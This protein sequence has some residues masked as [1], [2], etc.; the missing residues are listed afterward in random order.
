MNFRP[1]EACFF[2]AVFH[3]LRIITIKKGEPRVAVRLFEIG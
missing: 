3:H 1:K 2:R